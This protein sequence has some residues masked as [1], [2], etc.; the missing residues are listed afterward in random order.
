MIELVLRV[1]EGAAEALSDALV[2]EHAALAVSVEDAQ[3]GRAGEVALF[4]EPGLPR[5]RAAWPDSRLSALFDAMPRAEAAAAALLAAHP[6]LQIEAM[7]AVE[8]RDWVRATQAQFAPTQIAPGYWVVPSWHAPPA[9]AARVIRL[10]PGMAFGTG[11]HPT[12]R[13]CLRWLARHAMRGA[14]VLD[15]GCGS[16]ILAIAAAQA[17]ARAVDAVDLDPLALEATRANAQANRVTL[18]GIGGPE[19]A[20]GP[21]DV[22]VA[23]ILAAP[24][25]VLAPLLCGLVAPGGRLALAGL[26]ER[27]VAEL[28]TAYGTWI[29]LQLD[30]V[31]DGWALLA[32]QRREAPVA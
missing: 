2:D 17:G 31:D 27:Q 20:R 28:Q 30:T 10:D 18:A 24:L 21:Y 3:A 11:T 22:V 13:L 19:T 5:A 16:G 12:T 8:D 26:L 32:G 14:R 23:N 7:R 25:K 9:Q 6:G 1:P 29:E 4:G 15:Y